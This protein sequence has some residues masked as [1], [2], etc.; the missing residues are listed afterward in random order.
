MWPKEIEDAYQAWIGSPK[1]FGHWADENRFYKFVW[2]CVDNSSG[3]PNEA[4]FA[5]RLE[6]DT[7]LKRDEQNY[8]HYYV[9]KA[10]SLYNH[11]RAFIKAREQ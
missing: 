8:P 3:A 5:D 2:A 11:L 1:L 10:Q 6:R 7:G 9:S 4:D